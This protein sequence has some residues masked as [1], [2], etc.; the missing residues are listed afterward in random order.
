MVRYHIKMG[1]EASIINLDLVMEFET[2][3]YSPEKL[4]SGMILLGTPGTECSCFTA[5]LL[6]TTQTV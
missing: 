4:R 5:I 6:T 3:R 2:I 1:S